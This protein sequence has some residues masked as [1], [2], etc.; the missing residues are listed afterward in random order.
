[1]SN[2][3]WFCDYVRRQWHVCDCRQAQVQDDDSQD[4]EVDRCTP[5]A[6]VRNASRDVR[7]A[8]VVTDHRKS[9]A[10]TNKSS[11]AAVNRRDGGGGAHAGSPRRPP[12]VADHLNAVATGRPRAQPP[13][14][15][16]GDAPVDRSPSR[17]IDCPC[18]AA[19]AAA[20]A[21][22]AERRPRRGSDTRRRPQS[23]PVGRAADGTGTTSAAAAAAE[24]R[25]AVTRANTTGGYL[26][27]VALIPLVGVP[28]RGT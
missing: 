22:D 15:R 5:P 1:M 8:D 23:S 10:N 11:A 27:Q 4:D 20:A 18:A 24:R 25:A 28:V 13:T 12:P 3:I 9:A 17:R 2:Q 14:T 7:H 16:T 19:A 26:L 6:P 21:P